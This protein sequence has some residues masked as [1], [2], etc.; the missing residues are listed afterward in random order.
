MPRFFFVFARAALLFFPCL[1][2]LHFL[3]ALFYSIHTYKQFK[4]VVVL[5][6]LSLRSG[7][8]AH[9][10]ALCHT[11]VRVIAADHHN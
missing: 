7:S 5:S 10:H 2:G 4:L 11:L 1:F 3:L 8:T 9:I 6:L